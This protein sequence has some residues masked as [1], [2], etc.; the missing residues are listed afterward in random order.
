[1]TVECPSLPQNLVEDVDIVYGEDE[2]IR[3]SGPEADAVWESKA[4]HPRADYID[5]H[6]EPGGALGA[7]L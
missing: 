6:P 7:R 1:M 5:H 3:F 2:D 4:P